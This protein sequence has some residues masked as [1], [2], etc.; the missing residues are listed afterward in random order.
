VIERISNFVDNVNIHTPLNIGTN[1]TLGA[2]FN[3]KFTPIKKI[4]FNGNFNYNFFKLKGTFE[5]QVFDF[6]ADRWSGKLN[7]KYKASKALDIEITGQYQSAVR[8]VQ[9]INS[10]NLFADFGLRYKLKGGKSVFSF[11]VRDIF[12]FRFR[13][14]L[15]SGND[16]DIY[17][18]RTRGRFIALGYSYSFGKGEAIEF[19][20][21]VR[22]G[23]GGRRR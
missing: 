6:N 1:N 19:K 11:S 8:T 12:A 20:G 4:T 10:A 2:E 15:I 21:G 14:S 17:S 3:F 13:E 7:G 9:G 22:R 23:G 5:D 18:F 16:F